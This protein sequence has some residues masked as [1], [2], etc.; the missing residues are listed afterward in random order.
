MM[1][2]SV[3]PNNSAIENLYD[4]DIIMVPG[5]EVCKVNSSIVSSG[6]HDFTRLH[7]NIANTVSSVNEGYIPAL[8]S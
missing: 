1:L 7:A 5:L 3:L 8:F 2:S 6:K 4:F